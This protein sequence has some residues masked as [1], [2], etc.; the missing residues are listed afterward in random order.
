MLWV[1]KI[2]LKYKLDIICVRPYTEGCIHLAGV[3]C[4]VLVAQ[5]SRVVRFSYDVPKIYPSKYWTYWDFN[6]MMYESSSKLLFI[7]IFAPNEFLQKPGFVIDYS[8]ISKLLRY[9]AF[10]WRARELLCWL[11]NG[12]ISGI[13]TI[14]TVLVQIAVEWSRILV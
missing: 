11:K 10:T 6:F 7:Q 4:L 9:A 1:L 5:P 12:L 8:W 2:L 14:W 3:C 13:L